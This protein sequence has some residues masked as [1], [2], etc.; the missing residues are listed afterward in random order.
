MF[1]H[2]KTS[3][4]W[5]L[6]WWEMLLEN[7]LHLTQFHSKHS[8]MCCVHLYQPLTLISRWTWGQSPEGESPVGMEPAPRRKLGQDKEKGQDKESTHACNQSPPACLHGKMQSSTSMWEHAVSSPDLFV[9]ISS[10][11]ISINSLSVSDGVFPSSHI[12]LP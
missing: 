9:S 8:E 2:E 3:D 11:I 7:D 5:S 10:C 4:G 1:F 6:A 12:L